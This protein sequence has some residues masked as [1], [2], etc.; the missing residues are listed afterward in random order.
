MIIATIHDETQ[1]GRK[2]KTTKA[3]YDYDV[4]SDVED[5][6]VIEI[7]DSSFGWV[8]IGSHNFTP[9]AWGTL[10]GSSFNP[11]LNVRP[12]NLLVDDVVYIMPCSLTRRSWFF[13]V[14]NYELGVVLPLKDEAHANRIACWKRPARKYVLGEDVPWVSFNIFDAY[15][16][17]FRTDARR[18]RNT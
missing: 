6:D 13:Q 3:D 14:T 8:Y 17:N 2:G 12:R 11:I 5:D 7:K 4:D 15:Y 10:S 9:S 18:I 1:F 16:T